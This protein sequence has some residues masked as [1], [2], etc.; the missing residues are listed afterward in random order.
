ML[1]TKHFTSEF[2]RSEDASLS[3]N[4][5]IGDVSSSLAVSL[6]FCSF[7]FNNDHYVMSAHMAS[8]RRSALLPIY[9][10]KKDL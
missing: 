4:V 10:I 1:H 5:C 6:S 7:L 9:K 3:F 8:V 2:G